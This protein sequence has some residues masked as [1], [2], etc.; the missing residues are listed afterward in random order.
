MGHA[1]FR[2]SGPA[3][4]DRVLNGIS[5][6]P[7]QERASLL[8]SFDALR[9]DVEMGGALNGLDEITDQALAS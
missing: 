5:Q 3:K 9:R 6:E 8:R 2:P 1:A 7:L 4:A